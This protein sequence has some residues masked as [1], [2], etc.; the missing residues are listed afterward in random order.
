M[1]AATTLLNTLKLLLPAL[2]PSWRF[3]E[4]V[5]ASPRIEIATLQTKQTKPSNWTE[6]RP[7]PKRVS[8]QTMLKHLFWN[9]YRNESLF[10]VSCAERIIE[11][12]TDHSRQE[13]LKR[14]VADLERDPAMAPLPPYLQFRLVFVSR[15]KAKLQRRVRYTSPIYHINGSAQK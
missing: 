4:M 10:L 15:N 2:I 1:G 9:P 5:A 3:F 7:K 14:I 8:F 11:N 12:P 6:V 13:I